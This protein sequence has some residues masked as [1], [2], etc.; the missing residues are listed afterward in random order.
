MMKP[1][2][3][4][5]TQQ[6]MLLAL[7]VNRN[8]A[9]TCLRLSR[10][11][12]AG[13]PLEEVPKG[14]IDV[15]FAIKSRRVDAPKGRLRVEVDFRMVLR[16]EQEATRPKPGRK[17]KPI[18]NVEC[19]FAVDYQLREGFEPSAE[20]VRTFKDG[21]VIFNCWPYFREYLQESIQRMGYPPLTAPFLRVQPKPSKSGKKAEQ[22]KAAE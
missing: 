3:I 1:I 19:T 7:E 6:Q 13:Q 18:A 9:I 2:T 12:M 21:N 20:H 16:V 11:K 10:S 15:E 8:A 14:S 5:H 17:A 22:K 4:E